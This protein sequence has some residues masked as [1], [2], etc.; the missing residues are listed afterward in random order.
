M[1]AGGSA[2]IV[3]EALQAIRGRWKLAI[4]FHLMGAPRLRFNELQRALEGVSQKVLTQAVRELER[5]GIV[6]RTVYDETP[7]HTD[8]RLTEVGMALQLALR[9]LRDWNVARSPER[10]TVGRK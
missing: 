4:V 6:E 8:Y 5:D 1:G 7:P 9:A 10:W 2:Q 3:D